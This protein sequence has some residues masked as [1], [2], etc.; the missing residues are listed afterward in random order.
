M[1]NI[2]RLFHFEQPEQVKL[3]ETELTEESLI[4]TINSFFTKNINYLITA[5]L[6]YFTLFA[7]F[8]RMKQK[9]MMIAVPAAAIWTVLQAKALVGTLAI[10]TAVLG[11]AKAYFGWQGTR[12]SFQPASSLADVAQRFTRAGGAQNI[13]SVVTDQVLRP[14]ASQLQDMEGSVISHTSSPLPGDRTPSLFGNVDQSVEEY[15]EVLPDTTGLSRDQIREFGEV[16][17]EVPLQR[18]SPQTHEMF[19]GIWQQGLQ[20]APKGSNAE[21]W[22]TEF[23]V[24]ESKK[25]GMSF[26][27]IA[28]WCVG[29]AFVGLTLYGLYK[30]WCA[31]NEDIEVHDFDKEQELD[32]SEEEPGWFGSLCNTLSYL[33]PESDGYGSDED[34]FQM[35]GGGMFIKL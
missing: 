2:K 35:L 28:K 34:G 25:K 11:L 27:Q 21:D 24:R 16:W 20:Q 31:S 29:L 19:E 15:Q 9:H 7:G 26:G 30:V 18:I 23:L 32:E 3:Q 13:A 17:S 33:A 1:E 4:G 8:T 22:A 12:A 5:C 10:G 6:V 14:P